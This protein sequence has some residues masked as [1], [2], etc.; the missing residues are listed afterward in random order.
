MQENPF[1]RNFG[2]GYRLYIRGPYASNLADSIYRLLDNKE[3]WQ[4]APEK[5]KLKQD[6]MQDLEKFRKA[7]LS[8]GLDYNLLESAGTLH[9]LL[10]KSFTYLKDKDER[11][12]KA[13]EWVFG[14]YQ[15]RPEISEGC[16]VAIQ[17]LDELKM[18]EAIDRGEK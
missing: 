12:D 15:S 13:K 2:F 14:H 10:T 7:F 18:L 9:F 8:K 16:N 5:I 1:N 11:I 3:E 4:D 17:K 6:C